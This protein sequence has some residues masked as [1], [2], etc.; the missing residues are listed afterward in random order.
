MGNYCSCDTNPEQKDIEA[1]L[2][3]NPPLLNSH[4]DDP[5]EQ[6]KSSPHFRMSDL[7][8]TPSAQHIPNN[9]NLL[10]QNQYE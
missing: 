9:Q 7:S 1:Y 6:V 8:F 10:L 2:Q 4:K 5:D 3:K